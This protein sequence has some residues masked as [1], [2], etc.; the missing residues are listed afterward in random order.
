MNSVFVFV[1]ALLKGVFLKAGE[2]FLNCKKSDLS[3]TFL[4]GM[5]VTQ[6]FQGC[7]RPLPPEYLV[8]FRYTIFRPQVS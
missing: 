4:R 6:L 3:V 7:N 8:T 2:C 1:D 5:E